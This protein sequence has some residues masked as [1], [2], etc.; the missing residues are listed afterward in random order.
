MT[1]LASPAGFGN[2][3]EIIPV[4]SYSGDRFRIIPILLTDARDKIFFNFLKL[5]NFSSTIC[6]QATLT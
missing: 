2:K 1:H 6:K 5:Y 3:F 4:L